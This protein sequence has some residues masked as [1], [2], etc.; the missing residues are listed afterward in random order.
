MEFL[1]LAKCLP[2]SLA[3]VL[4]VNSGDDGEV[5]FLSRAPAMTIMDVLLQESEEALGTAVVLADSPLHSLSP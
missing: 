5:E 1:E 3:V 4:R 2:P